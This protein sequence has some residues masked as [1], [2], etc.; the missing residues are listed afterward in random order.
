MYLV[1][2]AVGVAVGDVDNDGDLDI[3]Q[4]SGL[5][6]EVTGPTSRSL[7]LMNLGGGIFLDVT[8]GSGLEGLEN[9]D[10]FL[11]QFADVDNDGDLDLLTG[12]TPFFLFLNTGDGIFEERTR[13]AGIPGVNSLGDYDDDGYPD[14]WFDV[15]LYRNRAGENHFLRIRLTG[16]ESNRDGIGARVTAISGELRQMRELAAGDG[17]LQ[18]EQ[19]VHFGLAQH[20]QVDR[21]EIRWP[22]G[23][24]DTLT[25]IPGDMEIHVVE[26][27]GEW[28]P[29]PRTV[30]ETPPPGTVPFG[31]EILFSAI[32]R[33]ALFEP[34]A[35]ITSITA[36]LRNIGGPKNVPLAAL[37]DGCYQLVRQVTIAGI[38]DERTVE[39]LILQE[40]SLGEHWIN[41]SRNITVLGAPSTAVLESFD[42]TSPQDFTL[43]QN[44]PNPFNPETTIHFDLPRPA[45]IELAVYNLAAQRVATLARGHRDA[46]SHT[47]RWDVLGRHGERIGVWGL[48]LSSHG[49]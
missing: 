26:G 38:G 22:S 37:G 7:L 21:L 23:L 44:Y 12:E 2:N 41:L 27:C 36:D 28:Y 29:A 5:A 4:S 47:L 40:T 1:S 24:V 30:W 8:A 46:G 25:N 34:T 15:E 3:F 18:G 32:V 10:L 33:P 9:F 16:T 14:V 49:R 20:S 13:V 42:D 6:G 43:S 48:L 45:V 17:W 35:T 39:V 19:L 31:A 11:A